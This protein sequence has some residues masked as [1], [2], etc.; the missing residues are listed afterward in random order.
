MK[1][2]TDVNATGAR[3][4]RA[5][6]FALA[7]AAAAGLAHG[8]VAGSSVVATAAFEAREVAAG[9]SVSRQILGRSVVNENDE[10]IGR[11]QDI[12]VTPDASVSHVIVGAGGFLGMRRHDVAVPASALIVSSDKLVLTGATPGLIEVLP[13]FEYAR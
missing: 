6:L 8:Q 3:N 9:W 13:K 7:L 2:K 5:A 4:K 12:I 11:V 10:P 1:E